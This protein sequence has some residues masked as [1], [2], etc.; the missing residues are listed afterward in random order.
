MTEREAKIAFNLLS[1][2]GAVKVDEMARRYGSAA[3]AWEALPT[4]LDWRGKEIHWEEELERAEKMNIRIVTDVEKEYPERLRDVSSRPMVLY[5]VGA[6]EAL[7]MPSVAIVGTRRA[8]SYG[9]DTAE[10]LAAGLAAAG[11]VV[12]SGLALGIDAAAHRGALAVNGKTV[13]VLG[14]AIDKFFPDR[15]RQLARDMVERGGA[16]I[17]EFPLGREPDQMTFPQRNR[18]VAGLS[19]GVIAV[20]A[21]IKSGA[22]IT[23]RQAGELG[24]HVM[25][26]PGR[27]DAAMST[28]CNHLIREGATL[29]TNTDDVI[30]QLSTFS[31]LMQ[32][33]VAQKQQQQY[34]PPPPPPKAAPVVEP[35]NPMLM[36]PVDKVGYVPVDPDGYLR[37]QIRPPLAVDEELV[38]KEVPCEGV[39]IDNI[40]RITHLP[41]GRVNALL[42]ALRLKGYIRFLPGSRAA[43]K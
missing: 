24:R 37:A 43:R 40:S 11:W 36:T 29:V 42:A 39:G 35:H 34:T 32:R 22:L 10:R 1:G 18:L 20:E 41:I 9:I 6:V 4:H 25:A 21:P 17:S 30:E 12:V 5:V 15:N 38:L 16:V 23:C 14:G 2:V 33:N 7:S 31:E 8:T 28:G 27:V 3:A 26:V 19:R 13:G